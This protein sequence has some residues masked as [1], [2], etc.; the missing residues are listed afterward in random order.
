MPR[1]YFS[2]ADVREGR[3]L[4]RLREKETKAYADKK[5]V[6]QA[7]GRKAKAKLKAARRVAGHPMVQKVKDREKTWRDRNPELARSSRSGMRFAPGQTVAGLLAE[8]DNKCVICDR[9]LAPGHMGHH[10]DHCHDT[11]MVRGVLCPKCNL[12]IGHLQDNPQLLRAAAIYL[13]VSDPVEYVW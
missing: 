11:K 13:E 2:E 8:Q 10:V 3:R 9:E 4:R 12:G 6:R 1:K 7:A 5:P